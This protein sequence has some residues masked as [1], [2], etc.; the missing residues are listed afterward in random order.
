MENTVIEVRCRTN[1]DKWK[2]EKWPEKMVDRPILGDFVESENGVVA[3][4]V[5][6]T[7]KWDK[8]RYGDP[9]RPRP[10]IA[11]ELHS[12]TGEIPR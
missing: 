8:D 5:E 11:V 1:I 12:S 4:V 7:H 6:I 2:M 9:P 10:Y 3:K